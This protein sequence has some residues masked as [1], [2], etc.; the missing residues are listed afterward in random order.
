MKNGYD[1]LRDLNLKKDSVVFHI[2]AYGDITK[3]IRNNVTEDCK[4]YCFDGDAENVKR[5]KEEIGEIANIIQNYPSNIDSTL[6]FYVIKS[7]SN[8]DLYF[9]S[10]KKPRCLINFYPD[11]KMEESEAGVIRIDDYS[12]K[13]EI[14]N[15]IWCD[16]NG[17][18]I[19]F[20]DSSKKTLEKTEYILLKFSNHGLYHGQKTLNE[21]EESLGRNFRRLDLTGMTDY[22]LF[23]NIDLH[24]NGIS[25]TG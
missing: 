10:L 7:E 13:F 18:E 16:V 22:A 2:G 4:I 15:F 25:E 11:V 5:K 9:S 8:Q 17:A 23:E 1:F 21:I 19:D 20:I 24:Q 3:S 12:N 6:P 14:V